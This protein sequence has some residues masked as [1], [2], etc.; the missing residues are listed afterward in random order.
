MTDIRRYH[1]ENQAIF[2][3]AVCHKRKPSLSGEREKNLLLDIIREVKAEM[4]FRLIAYVILDDHF[5]CIL[6]PETG[7]NFSSILQSIKLRFTHRLKRE[8]GITT[9]LSLW[10]RRFWDHLLRD[11]DD[12]HRHLDYI[13]YNPVKHGLAAY[14]SQWPYSTY[15]RDVADGICPADWAGNPAVGSVGAVSKCGGEW[16]AVRTLR[17]VGSSPGF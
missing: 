3:T 2:I 15:H 1:L 13:H 14:V 4:P 9:P 11:A 10:Q 5:H 6:R 8:Q 16:C 7:S 12:L 17:G